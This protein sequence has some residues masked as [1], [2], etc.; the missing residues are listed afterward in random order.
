MCRRL[1][2]HVHKLLRIQSGEDA[3]LVLCNVAKNF[4][5]VMQHLISSYFLCVW[6]QPGDDIVL[7]AQALEKL[8]LE[9][10]ANM[11]QEEFEISALTSK[12]PVKG[13]RKPTAGIQAV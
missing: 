9:K 10:V 7:M 4:R 13:G 8:F 5:F 12:A 3:A 1:Q 2:H 6:F 11:P